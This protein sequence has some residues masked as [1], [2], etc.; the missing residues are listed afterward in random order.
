MVFNASSYRLKHF[1]YSGVPMAVVYLLI[2][3][4]TIGYFYLL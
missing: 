4:T 1:L 2:T 3:I